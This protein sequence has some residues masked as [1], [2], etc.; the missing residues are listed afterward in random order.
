MKP[1]LARIAVAAAA[2]SLTL[3]A[4]AAEVD[5]REARQQARIADGVQSGAL[6]PRETA[7]V[8]RKEA[9][10]DREIE[11]GRAANGGT[12]TPAERRSIN[13]QQNRVSRQIY[14]NKHDGQRM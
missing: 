6:T 5:R 1:L 2:L 9:R 14:R 12:L 3:P 8:E 13:R 7:R 11:A 10:I 4:L